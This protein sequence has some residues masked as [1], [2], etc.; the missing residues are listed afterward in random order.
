M[1]PAHMF[2]IFS[3]LMK[4]AFN[5]GFLFYDTQVSLQVCLTLELTNSYLQ[6]EK[7]FM[8]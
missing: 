6:V 7:L 3:K 5:A 8:K 2:I 4:P 1:N